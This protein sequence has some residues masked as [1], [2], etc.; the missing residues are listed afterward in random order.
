MLAAVSTPASQPTVAHLLLTARRRL[1]AAPFAPSTREAMLLLG[2]VLGWREAQVIARDAEPVAAELA[3]RFEALLERRLRGEP[4]AYLLGEREFYGRP[5]AVDPRVLIPRPETE[6]LVETALAQT[7]PAQPRI[8]DIGTGSGCLAVTLARE[9]PAARVAA[10]DVSLG[11]LAVAAAN[12]RRHGVGERVSLV[13]A[14]LVAGLDLGAFDLVVSNPPYVDPAQL[15]ELS[16]EVHGFEPHGALFAADAGL[17][18][19][20]RLL[21]AGADLRPGVP[22]LLEIGKGQ[23]EAVAGGAAAAGLEVAEVVA[24]YAGIPRTVVLWRPGSGR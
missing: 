18:V 9:L 24:D 16:V 23:V 6:H 21:A 11:A 22:L 1:A 8:L 19:L 15:P 2:H 5:F 4:V 10:T 12:V 17:A 3:A 13:A 7:L 20:R 14:D